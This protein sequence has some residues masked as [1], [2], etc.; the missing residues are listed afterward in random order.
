VK[1]WLSARG[2]EQT[3]DSSWRTGAG[4][5]IDPSDIASEVTESALEATEL[6]LHGRLELGLGLLDLLDTYAVAMY[7]RYE[8]LDDGAL[9]AFVPEVWD[10]YREALGRDDEPQ[11]V[12]YSL[13]VDWFEDRN[14]AR[15]WFSE[16]VRGYESALTADPP[17]S[18]LNRLRH[19]LTNSGPVPWTAKRTV[20]FALA[21]EP[22]LQPDVLEAL[23]RGYHDIYGD[24]DRTEALELLKLLAAQSGNP[25]LSALKSALNAGVANHY[26]K[27]D[28]WQSDL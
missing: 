6:S 24:L 23:L 22:R 21:A 4:D 13:W 11:A 8:L 1:S 10:Y 2:F 27:P 12:S 16:M 5:V 14:T 3:A 17:S 28:Q 26:I 18:L 25:N 9:S 20:L 15:L 19:V 7:L